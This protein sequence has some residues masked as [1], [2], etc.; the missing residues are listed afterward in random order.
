MTTGAAKGGDTPLGRARQLGHIVLYVSDLERSLTFY[1]DILCWPTVPHP[2]NLPIAVL[3][4]ADIH[5]DLLLIEVDSTAL[6]IPPK[7]RLGMYHFGVQVGDSDDDL[8]AILSRLATHPD[9]ATLVGAT[10]A[11]FIHS[12]YLKDPD[13]NEVELY[14]DMPGWN[15]GEPGVLL[16]T[17]RR[18]LNL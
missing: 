7:P 9:I 12:L 8:R 18:P 6:P 3:R 11:G 17:P 14:V 1:R 15:W 13:G 5:H 2:G 16:N 4:A 10:D